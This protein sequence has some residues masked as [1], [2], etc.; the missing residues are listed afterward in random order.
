MK[1][2]LIH[3]VCFLA[4]CCLAAQCTTPV[5][6]SPGPGPAPSPPPVVAD[7]GPTPAPTPV[8]PAPVP[9]PGPA[10]ALDPCEEACANAVYLKCQPPEPLCVSTC[11]Q[12]VASH[13]TNL[14][15]DCLKKATSCA[16]RA[17]C[18]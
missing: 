9:T 8:P 3:L 18:K 6:P 14:P 15:L 17:A 4:G 1:T 5:P 11:R 2:H 7:A 16:A 13:L 10:P 12:V